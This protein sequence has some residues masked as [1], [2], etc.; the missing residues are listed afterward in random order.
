MAEQS[1]HDA[2]NQPQSVDAPSPTD[3]S[4]N[5]TIDPAARAAAELRSAHSEHKPTLS[6]AA[7]SPEQGG[8]GRLATLENASK[9]LKGDLQRST[10]SVLLRSLGGLTLPR[11]L[12]MTLTF[13]RLLQMRHKG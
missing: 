5:K 1:L 9:T 6:T 8:N 13:D 12:A 3:V 4:A 2:V 7:L 11:C 10:V